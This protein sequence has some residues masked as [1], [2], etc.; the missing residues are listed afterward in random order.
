MTPKEKA[1]ELVDKFYKKQCE[2]LEKDGITPF[3]PVEDEI[4]KQCAIIAVDELKLMLREI[5]PYGMQYLTKDS[6]LDEV[7][8]EITNL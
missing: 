4:A 5:L 8:T 1:Q 2:I 7:K 3:D 6:E